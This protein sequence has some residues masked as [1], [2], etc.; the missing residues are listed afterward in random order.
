MFYRGMLLGTYEI[1][2]GWRQ[3]DDF[4]PAIAMVTPEQVQ[5]VAQKYLTPIN[6]TTG[7]LVPLPTDE[8]APLERMPGGPMS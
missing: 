3:I 8:S 6:R 5:Q 4:L 7:V 1:A 2:G